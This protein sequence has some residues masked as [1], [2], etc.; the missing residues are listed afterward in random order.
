MASSGRERNINAYIFPSKSNKNIFYKN[1]IFE[2]HAHVVH[3]AL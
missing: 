3:G 2:V 1:K